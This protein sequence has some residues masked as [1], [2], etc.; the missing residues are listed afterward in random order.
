MERTFREQLFLLVLCLSALKGDSRYIENNDISRDDLYSVF[1]LDLKREM[2]E[3]PEEL[4]YRRSLRCLDMISV[5]GQFT[6]TA[7]RPHLNCATFFMAEPNE[8][9]S[10]EYDHVDIDCRGGDFITVFDGWVMKGE[11]FPSSQ[12]HP[13]PLFERYVDYC[14]SG[15]VR[16]NVRSN[17]N[18]AM[19]FFRIHNEGSS[20]TVTI[21]KHLNPFPC[22]VISQ[23]PEGSYTMVIP[24]QHRNCS[25]SI[26]Y[27]VEIEISEFSLGH[28]NNIAK[29]LLPGCA[30][31]GDFVQLLGG[32]S[33]DSSKLVP[34]TDL[35]I[36]FTGP[37]Q[38]KIGCENSVVRMV[39]SGR[40]INRVSFSYRLLNSQELQ[41]FKLNSIDDFCFSN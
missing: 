13:V 15:A 8:V 35:C 22:N 24:Q 12:D 36:S 5:E 9:I 27:P 23:S 7:G 29:R 16:N 33:I 28:Y 19:L 10:L 31:T 1:N 2:P 26:V 18:V 30:E 37:T 3:I 32:N 40:F 17:Q 25:F 14:D 20:F 34:I 4:I 21:R 41:S 39:S 11:K 6:F 38:M